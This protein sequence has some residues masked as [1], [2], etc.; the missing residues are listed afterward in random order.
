MFTFIHQTQEFHVTLHAEFIELISF[1][2]KWV[3][4]AKI[5]D[6][7]HIG[8]ALMTKRTLICALLG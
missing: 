7:G 2:L 1:S 6:G 3:L 5:Q 8:H 4:M